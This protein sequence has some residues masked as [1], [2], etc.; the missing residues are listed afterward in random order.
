M[1][2]S[3]NLAQ[4]TACFCTACEQKM[5]FTFLNIWGGKEL[6][7][8][9]IWTLYHSWISVQ[10][11]LCD[12]TG[13]QVCSHMVS[14]LLSQYWVAAER[15]CG[16]KV[17]VIYSRALCRKSMQNTVWA[18]NKNISKT[19]RKG[20][21]FVFPLFSFV[22]RARL[23]ILQS[24]LCFKECNLSNSY[25]LTY[26]LKQGFPFFLP[27]PWHFIYN[28]NCYLLVINFKKKI[29]VGE[30]TGL[31]KKVFIYLLLAASGLSCAVGD[32]HCVVQATL[33][34]WSEG[35]RAW[36]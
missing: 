36:A 16:H 18:L 32:R 35:P 27:T 7:F 34:W 6:P 29:L 25:P 14:G 4:L 30:G 9:N 33:H 31:E 15:S 11:K 8:F 3:L 1:A 5:D 26:E 10:A 22:E 24:I 23:V 28:R 2:H 20:S 21:L 17:Y 12:N 13:M 19:N